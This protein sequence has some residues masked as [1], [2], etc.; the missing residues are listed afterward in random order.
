MRDVEQI[1]TPSSLTTFRLLSLT[2]TSLDTHLLTARDRKLQ[3]QCKYPWSTS[4]NTRLSSRSQL[5]VTICSSADL[6]RWVSAF[7]LA[8]VTT[9]SLLEFLRSSPVSSLHRI[10]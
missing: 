3:W 8:A 7:R 5:A 6:Q 2:T 4:S 1:S 9:M 10:R